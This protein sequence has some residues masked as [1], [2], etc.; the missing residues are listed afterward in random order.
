M[1]NLDSGSAG[2]LRLGADLPRVL[3]MTVGEHPTED[4]EPWSLAPAILSAT[5]FGRAHPLH[6]PADHGEQ[7]V[8]AK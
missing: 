7:Q 2:A 6:K 5:T 3:P 8:Q 1:E 4:A